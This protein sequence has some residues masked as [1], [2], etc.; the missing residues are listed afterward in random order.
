MYNAI[1]FQ[2]LTLGIADPSVFNKPDICNLFEYMNNVQRHPLVSGGII[3]ECCCFQ[4]SI[5]FRVIKPETSF[6]QFKIVNARLPG[7]RCVLLIR[8]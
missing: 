3:L 6:S 4:A 7:C 1:G 8:N 5:L 2:G